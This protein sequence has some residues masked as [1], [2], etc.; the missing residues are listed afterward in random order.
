M[1]YTSLHDYTN[2]T[3]WLVLWVR[4]QRDSDGTLTFFWL[5]WLMTHPTADIRIW[6]LTV[7]SRTIGF[8]FDLFA[9]KGLGNVSGQCHGWTAVVQ[10]DWR[11]W[12]SV[13]KSWCPVFFVLRINQRA[14]FLKI[15]AAIVISIK[16][17]T[18]ATIRSFHNK[19]KPGSGIHLC[20]YRRGLYHPHWQKTESEPWDQ[21]L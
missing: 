10:Q 4:H 17:F 16:E 21:C 14:A 8:D 11:D 19:T 18:I 7:R 12:T 5:S 15:T 9:K 6:N 2:K 3:V 1:L 13:A 20:G